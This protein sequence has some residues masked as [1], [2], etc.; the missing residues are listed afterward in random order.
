MRSEVAGDVGGQI[1]R[2]GRL[3]GVDEVEEP[4]AVA[5]SAVACYCDRCVAD[6]S[7]RMY[8]AP[9]DVFVHTSVNASTCRTPS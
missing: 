2:D 8:A 3:K 1:A 7:Y 6:V 4:H 9:K 5:M